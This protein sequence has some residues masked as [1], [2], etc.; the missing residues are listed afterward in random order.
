MKRV[1]VFAHTGEE[2]VARGTL[3]FFN[4][5]TFEKFL[6]DGGTIAIRWDGGDVGLVVQ[7][8][9][10]SDPSSESPDEG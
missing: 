5:E 10:A 6:K 4:V 1:M 8:T 9:E 7:G 2:K 3:D